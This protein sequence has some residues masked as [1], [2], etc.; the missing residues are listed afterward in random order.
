MW[1]DRQVTVG[2]EARLLAV[3]ETH[4]PPL[5]GLATALIDDALARGL[6]LR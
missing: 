4:W 6:I 1:Q 5:L 2:D 3:I